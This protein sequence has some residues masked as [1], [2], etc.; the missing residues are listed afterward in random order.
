M[1]FCVSF[2]QRDRPDVYGQ[3]ARP[4][5]LH[6]PGELH[7]LARGA[8]EADLGAHGHGKVSPQSPGRG[9]GRGIDGSQDEGQQSTTWCRSI[10]RPRGTKIRRKCCWRNLSFSKHLG[11]HDADF[12]AHRRGKSFLVRFLTYTRGETAASIDYGWIAGD[13]TEVKSMARLNTKTHMLEAK[14]V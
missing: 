4:G 9:R 14:Q 1:G 6:P 12:S 10:A 5:L 2:M 7:G 3:S 8:Q 13:G 11:A